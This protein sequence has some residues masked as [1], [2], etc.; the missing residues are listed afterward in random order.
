MAMNGRLEEVLALMAL[1]ESQPL[2][3]AHV[4]KLSLQLFD[5]LAPLHGLGLRERLLL[6]AAGYLH[7]IGHRFDYLQTGHHKESARVIR[8]H[9]WKEFSSRETELIAQIARYHR[10]SM[11]RMK[12]EDFAMLSPEDRLVVQWLSALLR[13][14]DALDGSHEQ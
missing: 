13:I 14:A 11:P 1:M 2:H 12:H 6:E 3:V 4:T 10:K 8:E 7:D 5:G 9:P